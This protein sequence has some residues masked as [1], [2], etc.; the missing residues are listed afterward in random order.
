MQ[1]GG[2]KQY[3]GLTVIVTLG[4]IQSNDSF[5][6]QT[7]DDVQLTWGQ[8]SHN[9]PLLDGVKTAEA[10]AAAQSDTYIASL[11]LHSCA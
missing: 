7:K 3:I 9:V 4:Q 8:E 6:P 11:L 1:T 2:G 5:Y 10:A